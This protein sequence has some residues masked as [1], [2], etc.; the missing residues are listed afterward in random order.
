MNPLRWFFDKIVYYGIDKSAKAYEKVLKER[1]HKEVLEM[2]RSLRERCK[3]L[4]WYDVQTK[5]VGPPDIEDVMVWNWI[6]KNS[7]GKVHLKMI[8]NSEG[9]GYLIGFEDESDALLFKI[10][11]KCR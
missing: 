1:D 8:I 3:I 10:K 7:N 11:F 9:P 6:E 2:E 5:A 4:I